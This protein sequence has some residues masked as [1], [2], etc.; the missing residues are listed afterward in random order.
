MTKSFFAEI[1]VVDDDDILITGNYLK[2]IGINWSIDGHIKCLTLEMKHCPEVLLR[3]DTNGYFTERYPLLMTRIGEIGAT[4]YLPAPNVGDDVIFIPQHNIVAIHT[5]AEGRVNEFLNDR[6]WLE[7][8]KQ[9]E[10]AKG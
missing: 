9:K 6:F 8:E 7:Q 1:M 2:R 5:L 4:L 10:A 3:L